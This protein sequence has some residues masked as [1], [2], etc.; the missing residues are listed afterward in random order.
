[1]QSLSTFTALQNFTGVW[2][3][4]AKKFCVCCSTSA[5]QA[6]NSIL[7]HFVFRY[8]STT[9]ILSST[10]HAGDLMGLRC[11]W[12]DE[13]LTSPVH[14]PP[15][16]LIEKRIWLGMKTCIGCSVPA[17][18]V[19]GSEENQRFPVSAAVC[20]SESAF[21]TFITQGSWQKFNILPC[22]EGSGIASFLVVLCYHLETWDLKWNQCLDRIDSM[23][24][25]KVSGL[26]RM[27]ILL[28][29]FLGS[30][31]LY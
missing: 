14:T 20:L 16:R 8:F 13:M 31:D 12:E 25:V 10:V 15:F 19:Q 29:S 6:R 1:M 22:M 9:N 26:P 30:L 27:L 11:D 18:S 17:G 4:S 23:I 24:R 7:L 21:H 3:D 28:L 5:F 2:L